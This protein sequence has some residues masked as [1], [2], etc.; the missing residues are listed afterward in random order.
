MKA[1][2]LMLLSIACCSNYIERMFGGAGGMHTIVNLTNF[3]LG[4]EIVNSKALKEN[5]EYIGTTHVKI[6]NFTLWA[7]IS[8]NSTFSSTV[9]IEQLGF[10]MVD[11]KIKYY[12]IDFSKMVLKF[13]EGSF[14]LMTN[15]LLINMLQYPYYLYKKLFGA[16]EILMHYYN[17]TAPPNPN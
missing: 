3:K 2:F 17:A 14:Q 9:F 15:N 12:F 5:I 8:A 16:K 11:Y 10:N 7:N 1:I 13:E 6:P 4:L